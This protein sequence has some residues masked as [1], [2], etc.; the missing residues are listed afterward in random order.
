MKKE[1]GMTFESVSIIEEIENQLEEILSRKKESIEKE[2]EEKIRREKE[3]AQ[4]RIQ[5][6]EAELSEEKQT[7]STYRTLFAEFEEKKQE[8]KSQIKDHLARAIELQSQIENMT[9]QTMNELK[10]VSELNQELEKL[11]HEALEKATSLKKTLEEKYGI[12]AELPESNGDT[13]VGV[14]LKRELLKL[15]K[16]KELLESTDV[17]LEVEGKEV[18]QPSP[19]AEKGENEVQLEEEVKKEGEVKAEA[20]E[21]VEKVEQKEAAEEEEEEVVSE[22]FIEME[23]KE[24]VRE[25]APEE[26][27][28]DEKPAEGSGLEDIYNLLEKYRKEEK[29]EG[30]GMISFYEYGGKIIIDSEYLVSKMSE[31][32]EEAKKLYIKL[33]QTESPREQFFVK[34]DIIRF[35]EELRKMMLGVVELCEKESCALPEFTNKIINKEVIK[36]I[37]ERVTLGNWSN[38]EDFAAF[39]MY[40]REIKNAFNSVLTPPEKYLEAIHQELTS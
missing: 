2:L 1:K 18:D 25:A 7:L 3:E 6:I 5:A 22:P 4:K 23:E 27:K 35:Q 13:E 28:E 17:Y 30:N 21:K 20:V 33:S 8:I 16:I 15:K 39:D 34:Q 26:V 19:G 37:L 10:V 14:D 12:V 24:E 38:Q 11:H 29:I 36:D 31:Y 9:A 32:V 40:A